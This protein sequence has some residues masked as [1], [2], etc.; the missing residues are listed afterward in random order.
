MDFHIIPECYVDT[1]LIETIVPPFGRG[2]NHQKGCSTV[3]K[4]MREHAL[5]RDGFAVGIIDKDKKELDYALLFEEIVDKGQLKLLKHPQKHHYFILIVPAME[6]WIL[7]N[8]AEVG[9]NLGDFEL[10]NDL[11]ELRIQSKKMTTKQD[12]RFKK[13]F[14]ELKRKEASGV[15]ILYDWI[16]YLK[17]NNYAANMDYFKD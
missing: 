12:P 13:L 10:S 7:N 16:S 1:N 15:M 11:N 3:A 6:K 5:L 4:T 14:R 9:L 2:Y 17:E 8:A